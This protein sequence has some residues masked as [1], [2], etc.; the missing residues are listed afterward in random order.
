MAVRQPM[1]GE[2][3]RYH[4]NLDTPRGV[5]LVERRR[6]IQRGR[7]GGGERGWEE[8]EGGKYMYI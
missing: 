7:E 3:V 8:G 1:R 6:K 5:V 4:G 2:T